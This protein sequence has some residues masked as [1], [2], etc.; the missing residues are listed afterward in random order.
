M[1]IRITAR[2]MTVKN[3]LKELIER[4]LSK[5]D[6]FFGED[7][8]ADVKCSRKHDMEIIEITISYGGT[9]FRSEE[10]NETFNNA[11]DCA[12]DSLERQIRKN[13]TRLEKKLRDKAFEKSIGDIEEPEEEEY[14]IHKKSFE[15]KPMTVEEAIMQMNLLEH[16]FY[17]FVNDESGKSCL[18]YK[19]KDGAYGLIT[20]A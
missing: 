1:R 10:G 15:I 14:V 7:T 11:L 9:L 19:R 5:F 16:Q 6:K 12:M 18:V 20:P 8:I 4:K 13:K 3:G 17:M 2:Q